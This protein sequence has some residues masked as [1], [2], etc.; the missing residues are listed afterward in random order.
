MGERI[1]NIEP[2]ASYGDINRDH[3]GRKAVEGDYLLT[4]TA[5]TQDGG[6]G[7]ALGTATLNYSFDDMIGTSTGMLGL[8]TGSSASTSLFSTFDPLV[9]RRW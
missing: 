5:Y 2:Y 1:E 6:K 4:A 8:G 9:A 7:D 3:V